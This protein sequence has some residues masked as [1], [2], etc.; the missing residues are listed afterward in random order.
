MCSAW[1]VKGSSGNKPCVCCRNVIGKRADISSDAYFVSLHT[2]SYTDL[3]RHTDASKRVDVLQNAKHNGAG[4]GQLDELCKA[5]GL[6]DSAESLLFDTSLRGVIRP[7]SGTCWDWMHVLVSNGL[8][9]V[10]VSFFCWAMWVEG[11]QKSQV[12]DFVEEF[13]GM[14]CKLSK[15]FLATRM[16]GDRMDDEDF[17]GFAGELMVL[18]PLLRQFCEMVLLPVRA[19][20]RHAECFISLSNI[21]ELMGMGDKAVKYTSYLRREIQRRHFL[22]IGLYGVDAATPKFHYTLHLPDVLDELQRNVSC[23]VGERKHRLP[24]SIASRVFN[25]FEKSLLSECLTHFIQQIKPANAFELE[26]LAK[27]VPLDDP[28]MLDHFNECFPGRREVFANKSATTAIGKVR[29]QALL[30][31][32]TN[33]GFQVGEVLLFFKLVFNDGPCKFLACFTLFEQISPR[34]CRRCP[35]NQVYETRCIE[36]QLMYAEL[37]DSCVRIVEPIQVRQPWSKGPRYLGTPEI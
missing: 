16:K 8:A 22:F 14:K 12:D 26:S 29:H 21:V 30:L 6:N 5:M 9:D 13:R 10:E 24:K 15:K 28:S 31:L 2:S 36:S 7:V 4:K 25:E 19:L 17:S 20:L 1:D 32:S 11:F 35:G 34:K 27:D 3:E 18:V 23:W 33:H 37:Q